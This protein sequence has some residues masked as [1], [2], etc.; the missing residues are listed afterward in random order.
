[1]INQTII[2]Q[3]K[4]GKDKILNREQYINF[5]LY[6]VVTTMF[7]G[8]DPYA[9]WGEQDESFHARVSKKANL[10]FDLRYLEQNIGKNN[11]N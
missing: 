1:M 2:V 4:L 6:N 8:V 11:E 7:P 3:D 10:E 5:I 9:H